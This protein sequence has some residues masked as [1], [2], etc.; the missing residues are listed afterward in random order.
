MTCIQARCTKEM[1]NY[2]NNTWPLIYDQHN[3]GRHQQE[4][5]FYS[6]ELASCTGPVLE[7]ACGTGMI[8]IPLLKQGID[9]YGIDL[10]GPMLQQ[11]FA[12]AESENLPGV[13][14]RVSQQN[15]TDFQID[16][17]FEAIFIPA[18]SFLHL[19]TQDDQLACRRN[20]HRHLRDHGTFMLNFFTPSPSALLSHVDPNPVFTDAGQYPHPW[21][22]GVISVS[23]RQTNDLSE[24]VQ[25]ITWRFELQGQVHESPMPIRWIYK[26]EFELPAKLSGF[27]VAHLYS[28]SDKS[29]YDG[30]V[31]WSGCWRS[32]PTSRRQATAHSRA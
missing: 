4:L 19:A 8:L 29:P 22:N 13:H 31:E 16:A 15:M 28:G 9:I 21:G 3:Q 18:R 30:E 23:M 32:P 2:C 25:H 6:R 7:V 5:A 14:R 12:K 26:T 20:I 10:F 1:D 27:T 17:E 11:L 24:Q